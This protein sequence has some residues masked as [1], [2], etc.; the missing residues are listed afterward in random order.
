MTRILARIPVGA[1][2]RCRASGYSPP[3]SL[4]ILGSPRLSTCSSRVAYTTDT[5]VKFT[6]YAV[7]ELGLTSA[8]SVDPDTAA[9]SQ[10]SITLDTNATVT[11]PVMVDVSGDGLQFTSLVA[12]GKPT[13]DQFFDL[14]GDGTDERL[15]A[16]LAP[17][18]DDAFLV[19]W[20]G[21][22][23]PV[24]LTEYLDAD[25]DPTTNAVEDL[26]AMAGTDGYVNNSDFSNDLYLWFD[27]DTDG[28]ADAGEMQALNFT[29]Q[30]IDVS[31]F[32][33]VIVTDAATGSIIAASSVPGVIEATYG[34]N[35]LSLADAV[36]RDVFLPVDF[37]RHR[38]G[39]VSRIWTRTRYFPGL[40]TMRI[41]RTALSWRRA[42]RTQRLGY[43]GRSCLGLGPTRTTPTARPSCSRSGPRPQGTTFNLSDGARLEGEP[44]DTWL[45]ASW[46]GGLPSETG[47]SLKMFVQ[48]DLS[49][50]IPLEVRAT[51][52][53][54][55]GG[56]VQQDTVVRD[57]TLDIAARAEL[58]SVAVPEN[59]IDGGSESDAGSLSIGL[60]GI[61]AS[62][63]DP[64]EAVEVVIRTTKAVADLVD[65]ELNG[66]TVQAVADPDAEVP[67]TVPQTHVTTSTHSPDRSPTGT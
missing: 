40:P 64:G 53:F 9:A 41:T 11:D 6:A 48:D 36:V 61:A 54:T 7:D 60:S 25:G 45:V 13:A 2:P 23:D 57:V 66:A 22:G 1:R 47:F 35:N 59:I 65:F 3:M 30:G 49:G 43:P 51:K 56:V 39:P 58:P 44:T 17:D 16:W 50:E 14:T 26:V 10:L 34:A 27:Q 33:D 20:D 19:T 29:G 42:L 38:S 52:V 4:W 12:D 63:P 46:D 67:P 37:A 8:Q 55:S 24:L 21:S 62:S 18:T 5:A 28:E 32:D 15:R 31:R